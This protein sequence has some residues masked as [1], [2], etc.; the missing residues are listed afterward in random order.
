MQISD[1]AEMKSEFTLHDVAELEKNR[2]T[3]VIYHS[4]N[5]RISHCVVHSVLAHFKGYVLYIE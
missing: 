4:Y 2:I 1:F 3:G 5:G